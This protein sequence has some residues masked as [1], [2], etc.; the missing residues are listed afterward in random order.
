M[1]ENKKK[2]N[3]GFD[4]GVAS[5]GWSLIDEDHNIKGMGVRLFNDVADNKDGSLKNEKRRSMRC[6]RRRIRRARNRKDA[7]LNF[8][9]A[10]NWVDSI[11]DAKALI[12]IDITKFGFNNP[13]EL[14]Y[15]AL[16]NKVS[17]E[18][19]IYILFHYLHHRGFFYVTKEQLDKKQTMN[20]Q[21]VYPT[22]EIYNFY[23]QNHYYKDSKEADKYSA[24]QYVNEIKYMLKQQ[25]V[26]DDFINSYLEIFN[27]V[28]PFEMGPGSEKSPT[29]Y[30]MWFINSKNELEKRDGET[31]WEALKGKCTYYPDEKRGGKDSP[32]AE[33]FNLLNDINRIR[34]FRKSGTELTLEQKDKIFKKYN[35]AFGVKNKFKPFN[36]EPKELIKLLNLDE[37]K[38]ESSC[39][40]YRIDSKDKRI[41]TELKSYNAIV[42]WLIKTEQWTKPVNILDIELLQKANGIFEALAPYQDAIKRIEE[43]NKGI[44]I[45]DDV[46]KCNDQ[47]KNESLIRDLKDL[48]Q[49]TH[50]LSYKAMLEYIQYC[51]NNLS[52]NIDQQVYFENNLN[53]FKRENSSSNTNKYI[54]K[55]IFDNEVISPTSKRAFIQTVRIMNKLIKSKILDDYEIDNITFELPRDKNTAD[56]KAKIKK[57]QNENKNVI[58]TILKDNNNNTDSDKLSSKA[59]WRLKLWSQQNKRDIYDGDPIDIND[60]ISGNGLDID[61]I[62]P[63][64]ISQDDSINNK[65]LTKQANNR[66]KGNLTPYQWLSSQGKFKEFVDRIDILTIHKKDKSKEKED[67]WM[68]IPKSKAYLLKFEGDPTEE[69]FD[70]IGRNLAD[71]RYASKLVLNTFQNFFK[72]HTNHQNA[73]VKVVRGTMT[74]FARY[75]IFTDSENKK[76]LL[77]K[78]RDVYCHHAIDASI[79]CWLGMNHQIQGLLNWYQKK[80]KD[81]DNNLEIKDHKIV[82]TKTGEIIDIS[83]SFAKKDENV[84]KFG[85]ELKKYNTEV[86][87]DFETNEKTLE[88]GECANK[89]KF[90]RMYTTKKNLSL[91]NETIYSIKWTNK[92]NGYL[93]TKLD[94]IEKRKQETQKDHLKRLDKYF[95]DNNG[96]VPQDARQLFCFHG[97]K[98]LYD[99]LFKIYNHYSD[100]KSNPFIKYMQA[101]YEQLYNKQLPEKWTPKWVELSNNKRVRKLKIKDKQKEVAGLIVLKEH[102]NNAVMESLNALEVRVYKDD[103]DKL[104]KIPINQK[105][106]TFDKVSKKLKIDEN[107]LNDILKSKKII[108]N[109]FVLLNEGCIFIEKDKQTEHNYNQYYLCGFGPYDSNNVEIKLLAAENNFSE[110]KNKEN[111][112]RPSISLLAEEFYIAQVDELGKIYNKKTFDELLK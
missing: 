104:V 94:L 73:K 106:L 72:N 14:K 90:S 68:G 96:N 2:I 16:S 24:R 63:F 85:Y 6:S 60:V 41:I 43:L 10:N 55:N 42:D 7:Y 92:E 107:K 30:G 51:A 70:F 95:K 61:H 98:K 50:S 79:I 28:R 66:F 74:N 52:Q 57:S 44:E 112:I 88:Y 56:E 97:D 87:K 31:L 53:H 11:D 38:D 1:A 13:I 100:G 22:E 9:V 45:L 65:V 108:K 29:P 19:L 76:S 99:E 102:D 109:K 93:V 62:I 82:N 81:D 78:D 91:S 48:T 54:S 34:L 46:Y 59:K 64:S 39:H 69:L 101:N 15:H 32:I 18:A 20:E 71:T 40:G 49:K 47:D 84:I 36:C 3:I 5:V 27:M 67:A 12:N 25:N 33:I 26:D 21:N 37:L 83:K 23:K 89:I 8:L 77:P 35:D 75:Y 58:D 17:K 111:R 4:I 105:V 86:K 110:R 103:R 80:I